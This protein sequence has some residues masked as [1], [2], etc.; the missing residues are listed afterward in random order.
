M[1]NDLLGYFAGACVLV[2]SM[3]VLP[4]VRPDMTDQDKAGICVLFACVA[5]VVVAVVAGIRV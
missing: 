3:L 1:S 2:I 5:F 4:K